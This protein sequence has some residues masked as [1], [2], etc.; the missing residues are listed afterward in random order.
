M[1]S[2]TQERAGGD[3]HASRTETSSLQ[4][5]Y[6]KHTPVTRVEDEPGNGTL[7]GLQI[8]VL[9]EESPD[10][11]SV[12]PAVT[13]RTRS[14]DSGPLATIEHAELNH[15]EISCASHDSAERID[16]A[17]DG[18]LRD[19]TD[20]GIARHLPDSFERARNQPRSRSD[21]SG[22]YGRFSAGMPG[23]YHSD[24]EFGFKVL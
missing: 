22:G 8:W 23:T 6:A 20:R 19:A 7:H 24:V 12:E 2:A 21:T 11:T 1:D 13:L 17:D 10:R 15:G 4:G 5:L 18:S 14:P 9:L 3:Y 16:L